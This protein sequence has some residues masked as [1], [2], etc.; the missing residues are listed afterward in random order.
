MLVSKCYNLFFF[1]LHQ[2]MKEVIST[3][4]PPDVVSLKEDINKNIFLISRYHN[5]K[6]D[7]KFYYYI[8]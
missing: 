5:V 2:S 1:Y 8:I 7:I 4:S 3:I 6:M